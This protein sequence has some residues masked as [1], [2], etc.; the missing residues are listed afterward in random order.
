MDP[1]VNVT[2]TETKTDPLP[3]P[4]THY[5]QKQQQKHQHNN[6]NNHYRPDPSSSSPQKPKPIAR[7]HSHS[8]PISNS[9]ANNSVHRYHTINRPIS[10]HKQQTANANGY[11][12]HIYK[13]KQP[14]SIPRHINGH[15]NNT[16]VSKDDKISLSPL[17]IKD[18]DSK[19]EH[20]EDNDNS[21]D[22]EEIAA[23]YFI[24][25]LAFDLDKTLVRTISLHTNDQP[26][27]EQYKNGYFMFFDDDT[28]E[29]H[30]VYKRP[31]LKELLEFLYHSIFKTNKCKMMM[32]THG[33]QKYAQTILEKCGAD[34][35][36]PLML[37]RKD[38]NRRK[39]DDDYKPRRFKTIEKMAKAA[40][41]SVNDVLMIDDDPGV[42]NRG[43][44]CNGNLIHIKPF[45]DPYE[46]RNDTELKKLMNLLAMILKYGKNYYN[47][48]FCNCIRYTGLVK[49]TGKGRMSQSEMASHSYLRAELMKRLMFD[50][51]LNM[52][53]HERLGCLCLFDRYCAK[54]R[55]DW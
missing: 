15:S 48:I 37:P 22:N 52:D 19:E 36:F 27:P 26:Q 53:K 20:D 55:I 18:A 12:Q 35:L 31:Y 1:N 2:A 29:F 5:L 46:Q 21:D 6:N 25:M 3:K 44:R 28:K 38:W 39:F 30:H 10:N 47:K 49:N 13:N 54:Y 42:Y 45:D 24:K 41:M 23:A 40:S 33:T 8:H 50:F 14:Q 9:N 34:K 51:N 11:P 4:S 43:D 32:C 17:K 16:I 7:P